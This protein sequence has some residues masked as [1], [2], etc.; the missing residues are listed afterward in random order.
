MR[1]NKSLYDEIARVAH[2]LYE[3]RGRVHGYHSEDWLDAERI[4]LKRHAK[5]IE[6]EGNTIGSTKEKKASGKT[7]PKTLKTSKK[8][9]ESSSQTK[10]KKSLPKKKTG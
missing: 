9:S 4:V 5:E 1:K 6:H 7:E 10:T 8:T 3:K 2:D